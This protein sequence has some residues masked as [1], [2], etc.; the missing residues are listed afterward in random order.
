MI[1]EKSERESS[2]GSELNCE[3]MPTDKPSPVCFLESNVSYCRKDT[4]RC[5]RQVGEKLE[6]SHRKEES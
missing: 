2:H 4:H 3:I 1:E 6:G 5:G